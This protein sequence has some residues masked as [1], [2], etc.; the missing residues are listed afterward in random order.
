MDTVAS[1]IAKT[2]RTHGTE[3]FFVL[4]GG[5]QALWIA[6][7]QEGIKPILARSEAS[8][9][10][11]AD[12]YARKSGKLGV[13]YGQAGPGTANAA[14]ALAD[15]YWGRS[16]VMLITTIV[17]AAT[18]YR[19]EYQELETDWMLEPVTEQA[20]RLPQA[21]RIVDLL[22]RAMSIAS[23]TG[24][25]SISI[26]RDWMNRD[27]ESGGLFARADPDLATAPPWPSPHAVR[28]V[29]AALDAAERPVLLVG[30][31]GHR[32]ASLEGLRA[33]V[34]QARIPV[35]SSVGGKGVFDEHDDHWVGVVGKYAGTVA[36]EIASQADLVL[37]LGTD[38]GGLETDTYRLFAP[39][40]RII[41]VDLAA[42]LVGVGY[43][44]DQGICADVGAFLEALTSQAMPQ[45]RHDDWAAK[46]VAATRQWRQALADAPATT[47]AGLLTPYPVFEVLNEHASAIDVVADTGYM[48]AWTSVFFRTNS[49]G[50]SYFRANGSLGWAFPA[51]LGVAMAGDARRTVCVTGDGGFGYHVGD[52]ETAAR[53]KAPVIV[54]ILNNSCLAFEYHSQ[55]YKWGNNVVP[56]VNDFLDV[57]HAAVAAA[58]G[59][60]SSRVETAGELTTAFKAALE[61]DGPY[62]IDVVVDREELAP[63]TSFEQTMKRRL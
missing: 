44:P 11:M 59:I 22:A 9:V 3:Y 20:F 47:E 43:P 26:P 16:P 49:P 48:A 33:L 41:Q 46:A 40:A 21:S 4:T 30:A 56:A 58:F 31:G 34:N 25:T 5:D 27:I 39:A 6:L 13:V 38:L 42:R 50:R 23:S 52:L 18:H 55:R 63:V 10:Y 15:P 28:E 37:A 12:G 7:Q 24:P 62:V 14:A 45:R 8:A 35:I 32:S 29:A 57:D 53:L 1:H 54:I 60:P 2:L 51:S 61:H 19:N 17:Q 36:N